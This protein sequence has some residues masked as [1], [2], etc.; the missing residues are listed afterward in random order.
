MALQEFAAFLLEYLRGRPWFF[1]S[2]AWPAIVGL[3]LALY[4]TAW[5]WAVSDSS[6]VAMLEAN[7]AKAQARQDWP[8]VRVGLQAILERKPDSEPHQFA[9]AQLLREEGDVRSAAAMT[10]RLAPLD[11]VGYA[12]AL[13]RWPRRPSLATRMPARRMIGNGC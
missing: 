3:L 1:L 9:F 6:V 10:A 5:I 7:V 2:L 11:R 4:V 12:P 13:S 8:R